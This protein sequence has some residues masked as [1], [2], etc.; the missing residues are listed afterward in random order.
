MVD[1]R[2]AGLAATLDLEGEHPAGGAVPELAL[3]DRELRV[4]GEAGVQHAT[5]AVLTLEPGGEC[6]GVAAVALGPDREGQ[7]PAQDQ[8]R[9]ERPERRAGLDLDALD[10]GDQRLRPRHHARDEVAV[11]AQELG[12]RLDHEIGPELE[13]A[14]DIRARERVVDDVRRPVAVGQVRER[15]VVADERGRVRDGLRVQDPGRSRGERRADGVEI[16]HVDEVDVDPETREG[17][18]ELGPGRAVHR[19]RGHDPVARPEERRQRRVD[20]AHPRRQGHARLAAG[21]LGVC[22]GERAR[23]RVGDAAVGEAGLGIGRDPAQ[24]VGVG[25]GEGR[26]LVDRARSSASGPGAGRAMPPGWPASRSRVAQTPAG[27]RARSR[28]GCYTGPTGRGPR[29]APG[30]SGCR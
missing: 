19:D 23:R 3:G 7:D 29:C 17:P 21:E 11:A 24:F 22:R 8:E 30:A 18:E 26:G 1:D 6:R 28:L 5:H 13:R 4:A 27:I 14:T 15:A 12:R 2:A 25:R 16:G 20:G 10:V 9:L